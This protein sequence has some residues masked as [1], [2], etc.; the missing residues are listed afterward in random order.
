MA[1]AA[2]IEAIARPAEVLAAIDDSFP[3]PLRV[4]RYE[5]EGRVVPAAA[6]GPV[7]DVV[8]ALGAAACPLLLAKMASSDR[9]IRFYATLC[10]AESRPLEALRSLGERLFDSDYGIRSIAIDGLAGYTETARS[11]ALTDVRDALQSDQPG[12]FQAAA[13]ALAKLG[14]SG[15]VPLLIDVLAQNDKSAEPARRALLKLTRQDFG[16]SVRKWRSWW[17][18]HRQQHRIEWLIDGLGH[19]D[20]NL[21]SGAVRE[22]RERTGETF[23][24]Y[25]DLPR[26]ER[27]QA[28]QRWLDWWERDG[29]ARFGR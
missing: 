22:L 19:K 10:A 13:N 29:R 17:N 20:E 21:R 9:D 1:A 3:G 14:D 11:A 7:L 28:R 16:T 25:H 2:R 23:G 12:R 26:R 27:E 4:E 5:L 18:K 15:A 24:F 8:V 6:H